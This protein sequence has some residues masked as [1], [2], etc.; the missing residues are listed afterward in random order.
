[1]EK[2]GEMK[3]SVSSKFL[4]DPHLNAILFAFELHRGR[5]GEKEERNR[6]SSTWDLLHRLP[7]LSVHVS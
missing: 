5:E 4:S 1:M 6:R 3:F 2:S 7:F